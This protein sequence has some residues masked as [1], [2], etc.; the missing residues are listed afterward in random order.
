MMDALPNKQVF[1]EVLV[2][3]GCEPKGCEKVSDPLFI[4]WSRVLRTFLERADQARLERV[5][6]HHA[7]SAAHT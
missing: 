5:K 6:L 2:V 1:D 3:S 7:H 4:G